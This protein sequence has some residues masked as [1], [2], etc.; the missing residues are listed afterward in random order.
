MASPSQRICHLKKK[1]REGDPKEEEIDL[2]RRESIVLLHFC[3]FAGHGV[4]A[5]A[6]R[7]KRIS[8]SRLPCFPVAVAGAWR[9][10]AATVPEVSEVF[11]TLL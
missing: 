3:C 4:A 10:R 11:P 8:Q 9:G 2:R 5:D 7:K 1:K 6:K